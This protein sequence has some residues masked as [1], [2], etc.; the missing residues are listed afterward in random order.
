LNR[1]QLL[2]HLMKEFGIKKG[3]RFVYSEKQA[4]YLT[5]IERVAAR[6]IENYIRP[7]KSCLITDLYKLKELPVIWP[8]DHKRR[9][10]VKYLVLFLKSHGF[11]KV[12][13]NNGYKIISWNQDR[14]RRIRRKAREKAWEKN[15]A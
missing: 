15:Q 2:E 5:K 7:L 12:K 14:E 6:L 10:V 1:K 9:Y 13:C 4:W 3:K 11:I 8:D